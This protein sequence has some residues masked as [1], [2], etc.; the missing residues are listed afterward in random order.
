MF[1]LIISFRKLKSFVASLLIAVLTL[2]YGG[3]AFGEGKPISPAQ[4]PKKPLLKAHALPDGGKLLEYKDGSRVWIENR[5][6]RPLYFEA[7]E[8]LPTELKP[9]DKTPSIPEPVENG[10]PKNTPLV[11]PPS[12]DPATPSQPSANAGSLTPLSA[13]KIPGHRLGSLSF[14]GDGDHLALGTREKKV[15]IYAWKSSEKVRDIPNTYGPAVL[16]LP[17]AKPNWL[18]VIEG[19]FLRL[20]D[21]STGNDIQTYGTN[22]NASANGLLTANQELL[23]LAS[24]AGGVE[25]LRSDLRESLSTL[26]PPEMPSKGADIKSSAAAFSPKESLAASGRPNGKVYIWSLRKLEQTQVATLV[27]HN[28]RVES[29]EF[30]DGKLL[31]L[32]KE[33][34]LK[35]WNLG[36]KEAID[37]LAVGKELRR[38]WLLQNGT[39]VATVGQEQDAPLQ[40]R[41]LSIDKGKLQSKELG[42]ISIDAFSKVDSATSNTKFTFSELACHSDGRRIA[43]A[44]QSNDA[45][46]PQIV[47]GVFELP[48]GRTTDEKPSEAG[49]HT[50]TF[51]LWKTADGKSQVEAKVVSQQNDVVKLQRKDNGKIIEVAI[52]KLSA[53]D[54]K[55]VKSLTN[56]AFRSQSQH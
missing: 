42:A 6:A 45:A 39:I 30:V 24:A 43:V 56:D 33:G 46:T 27:A 14:S 40:F 47:V 50:K 5:T 1:A 2:A 49:D 52:D 41:S 16:L 19:P 36:Q 31:S 38:G 28:S 34:N 48:I 3:V 21:T 8:K 20:V 18:Y 37:E 51:R 26:V 11:Q 4:I 23:V 54:Q 10:N 25:F 15:Q 53:E 44:T 55:F 12:V 7:G 9:K 13:W 32:G 29:L 22:S 35:L 17:G